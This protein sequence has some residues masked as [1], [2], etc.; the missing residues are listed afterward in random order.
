MYQCTVPVPIIVSSVGLL[1]KRVRV[2]FCEGLVQINRCTYH[3]LFNIIIRPA[4]R[5]HTTPDGFYLET[6]IY[7]LVI[8][9]LFITRAP[10]SVKNNEIPNFYP[11][12]CVTPCWK[13]GDQ[14]YILS[15]TGFGKKV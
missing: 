5:T 8:Y 9:V 2:Y 15:D 13:G 14:V 4:A 6:R 3:N 11:L 10:Q 12:L 1:L 7:K